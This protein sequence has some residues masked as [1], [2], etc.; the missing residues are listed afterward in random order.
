MRVAKRI[1]TKYQN[2]TYNR[3]SCRKKLGEDDHVIFV[4]WCKKTQR[5]NIEK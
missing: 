3:R 5:K 2:G 1:E 4:E